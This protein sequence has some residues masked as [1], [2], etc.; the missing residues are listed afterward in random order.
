MFH[1]PRK[2]LVA[3]LAIVTS[4]ALLVSIP[5]INLWIKGDLGVKKYT[6]SAITITNTKIEPDRTKPQ[7][8]RT[9]PKRSQP[10]QRSVKSGPRFAM[11]LGVAGGS[12]GA[13]I[14]TDLLQSAGGGNVGA[15][16]GDVDERP[17][18]R[19]APSFQAP[20]QIREAEIDAS[21]LLAF[22]VDERGRPYDIRVVEESPAGRGLAQAGKDAL[23]RSQFEPAMKDGR[24]VAFCGMEQPFEIKFRD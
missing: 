5:L 13:G 16:D 20:A 14:S 1:L 3:I 24:G 10:T 21:L 23:A 18:L 12:D 2:I 22:C 11:D 17:S 6:K 4:F 9:Q 7:K 15:K 19:S 8:A